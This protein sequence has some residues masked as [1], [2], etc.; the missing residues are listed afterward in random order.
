MET[1]TKEWISFYNDHPE[2][3]ILQS[4]SWGNLKA[5]FGWFP[6]TVITNDIGSQILFRKLPLGLTIAY[7]PKGP[8]GNFSSLPDHIRELDELCKKNRAVFLKMEPDLFENDQEAGWKYNILTQFGH[9]AKN[10][11]PQRTMIISL[12]GEPDEWLARMKQKTRYNIRLSEKKDVMVSQSTDVAAF[13]QL[14]EVTGTRNDFGVHSFEYYRKAFAEFY[15]AAARIFMAIY[16]GKPLAAIMVFFRGNLASYFYGASSNHE[17]NRMP[18]YLLQFEAMKWAAEQGCSEYDLWGVPDENEEVLEEAFKT[19]SDGLWGV[20]R[21]K[22]GFGGELM[23][24][25]AS[26]DRVYKP[27]LY[28]VY[29]KRSGHDHDSH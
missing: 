6:K 20:Y 24:A 13:Q 15:P 19:R 8:I 12:T 27:I 11:Q 29:L 28:K 17:R 4:P 2:A 25:V 21:F 3:H 16:Q 18:T 5:D 22:R 1:T 10:I 26:I 7:I 23:R 14:M 9:P